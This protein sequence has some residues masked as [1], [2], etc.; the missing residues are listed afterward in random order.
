MRQGAYRAGGESRQMRC[1]LEAESIVLIDKL[2]L[3][4]RRITKI[5]GTS[6]AGAV[7]EEKIEFGLECVK[8]Q[9]W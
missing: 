8:S 1:G 5:K 6:S 7:L 3:K 4:I 9:H 2:V